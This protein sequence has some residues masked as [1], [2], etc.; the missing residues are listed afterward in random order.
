MGRNWWAH[1]IPWWKGSQHH[2]HNSTASMV[3]S[4]VWSGATALNGDEFGQLMPTKHWLCTKTKCSTSHT[5]LGLI[6]STALGSRHC[7]HC[8][9]FTNGSPK[10][11]KLV[12]GQ[13]Q[14]TQKSEHLIPLLQRQLLRDVGSPGRESALNCRAG[15]D[16]TSSITY[17][18]RNALEDSTST[19]CC[20]KRKPQQPLAPLSHPSP[21][22]LSTLGGWPLQAMSS[23]D[24]DRARLGSI[25]THAYV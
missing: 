11:W 8:S 14:L 10:A 13:A 12:R 22:L 21:T 9:H 3:M 2:K 20:G 4:S 25:W 17:H 18:P 16:Q 15:S 7:S 19:S 5:L 23:P 1:G 6:L 24:P